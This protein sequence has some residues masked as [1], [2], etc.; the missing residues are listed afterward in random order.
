MKYNDGTVIRLREKNGGVFERK[1]HAMPSVYIYLIVLPVLAEMRL[2]TTVYFAPFMPI[3][4][5]IYG[6]TARSSVHWVVPCISLIPYGFGM[7]GIFVPI[8]TYMVDAFLDT[9]ASAV[10]ALVCLRCVFG[11][12]L[13]LVGPTAYQA[14]GLGWGNTML[15]FVTLAVTP[16]PYAFKKWG[17]WVRKKY[18]VKL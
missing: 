9:A 18:P 14:L 3:A 16:V 8:Q 4:L 15:G 6:W 5:F 12:V 7:L 10:A 11:A 2:A 1:L 17:G 13:P